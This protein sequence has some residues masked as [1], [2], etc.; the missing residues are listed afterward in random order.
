MK[1]EKGN[2]VSVDKVSR[3]GQPGNNKKVYSPVK[4]V[5]YRIIRPRVFLEKG[6]NT[7][8]SV[9]QL[10]SFSVGNC[11]IE[12]I[13][14]NPVTLFYNKGR[15]EYENAET[16]YKEIIQ[17]NLN[18]G[19]KYEVSI[20]DLHKIYDYLEHIQ[21]S[22]ICVYSAIEALSNVA[23]PNGFILTKKNNKGIMETWKKENIE[24]WISTTEKIS[25]IV[26]SIRKIE[27]PASQ[28]FWEDFIALKDIRDE[29]IH[30]KQSKADPRNIE[31]FFINTLLEE[32]IFTKIMAGYSLIKYFCEKDQ[33]HAYFPMLSD[34]I[35]IKVNFVDSF[36]GVFIFNKEEKH[37]D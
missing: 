37:Q 28:R 4:V 25:K 16:I 32:S 9:Q 19:K 8:A 7:V 34:E 12:F 29:I 22:I 31:G 13:T 3:S 35:P 17:P 2:S 30:Q 33:T 36:D 23:I 15:K 11:K 24:R 26:P 14:P 5:D 18:P 6:G 21:T 10:S 20:D 27:S 1:S